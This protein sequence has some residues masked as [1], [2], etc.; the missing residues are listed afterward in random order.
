MSIATGTRLG[1]YEITGALGAGGMGEVYRAHD[2]RLGRSVALK[3]LPDSFAADTDRLARFEREAR[4]LAALNHPQ[5]AHVYG[6]EESPAA[7]EG[8]PRRFALVM[9]LV[10]GESLA[11]RLDRGALPVAEAL[12]FARQVADGLAAAHAGGIIHRDLKP[13]NIQVTPEGKIKILDFGL[14]KSVP[15]GASG[16]AGEAHAATITSPAHMTQA[17]IVLGTAAYMS[18]EQAKGFA[19]DRR[20]DIWAYGCVVFEMLSGRRLFDGP[21]VSEVLANVL[22]AEVD[23]TLLPSGV[24]PMPRAFLERCL[25]RDL[26]Q[27]LQEIGDMRLALE[28]AFDAAL[29][30]SHGRG[31]W[32][33]WRRLL[34]GGAVAI[35]AAG[36]AGGV[37]WNYARTVAPAPVVA[38]MRLTLPPGN[39]FYFNGRQ[40]VAVS[41]SGRHVAYSAG[42]GL[43]LHSLDELEARPVAGAEIEGRSPFFSTDGQWIGYYAAGEL[44]RAPL[45]GGTPVKMASVVNPWG[46]S[47][48]HDGHVCYGQGPDGIWRVAAAGGTPARVAATGEGELAHGP[49]LLPDGEWVLFTLLPAG[50]GSWNRANI[51]AESLK[52]HERVTLVE[53]GRDARYLAS[54]HLI[55]AVNGALLAAPF[56]A[57]ARRPTAGAVPVVQNLWDAGTITGAAHYAVNASGS[58]VYVSRIGNSLRLTWVDRRGNEELIPAD[59]RP[60]RHP[61][62]SPDGTRIAVEVEEPAN[63]DV[64]VGE[65]ARGTF[66]RLTTNEDVDSDPIWTPD[67]SRVVFASVRDKTGLFWQAADGSGGAT[68]IADGTGGVRPLTWSASGELV[69]EELEGPAVQ[70][71]PLDGRSAPRSITIFDMPEYFNEKLPAISPDGRWMAY[72]STE[73][74]GMETYVR[75][76]PNVS[77]GRWQ[78]SVGGGFAPL[79]SKNGQEIYYRN[80]RSLMAVAVKTTP[81]FSAAAPQALFRLADYILAGTRGLRYDVA[82]DGRFLL[83]KDEDGRESLD[84]IVVVQNWFEELRRLVKAP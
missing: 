16:A 31:A 50:V 59:V 1:P 11:Q 44:R 24:P 63:T 68:H 45:T 62:V 30:S 10:P 37:A 76:F 12:E 13:A 7:T 72:Q 43:W 41:P 54:G 67:G 69:Y 23:W 64:W 15:P 35:L 20:A 28:G 21:D 73:S 51:V 8:A 48:G 47:W 65:V 18:P 4:A 32:P 53:G 9:E 5:I 25:H 40:L 22:R 55:Y 46:A 77:A 84:R 83:F 79:W 6:F 74:G 26:R 33:V 66:A 52:T 56:N 36:V 17:G 78:I 80:D 49:Q 29:G 75:P 58:L 38:R 81:G 39:D 82:P 3:L 70:V 34:A 42:L 2:T 14:A 19:V 27:R 57:A 71:L 60:Y 61:R